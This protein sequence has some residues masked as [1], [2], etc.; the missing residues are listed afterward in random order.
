ME[1]HNL[2]CKL[3]NTDDMRE[4]R[5]GVIGNFQEFTTPWGL[6][7]AVYADYTASGRLMNQVE[8]FMLKE[9]FP[10]YS[11]THTRSNHF[12][13]KTTTMMNMARSNILTNVH[14]D[15]EKDA[16]I[17][18]GAGATG[19]INKFVSL[20]QIS[21]LAKASMKMKYKPVVF[22][23]SLEHHSTI[24]PWRESG[25]LVITIPEDRVIGCGPDLEILEIYLKKYKRCSSL[26][27]GSFSAASNVTGCMADTDKISS[28]LHK[29]NALACFDYACAGPYCDIR[30]NPI[31]DEH[32]AK[33]KYPSSYKDAV[34]ISTHK[35][36]GGP[37]GSG[38]LVCKKKIIKKSKPT[39]GSIGGGTV[40]WVSENK[41]AYLKDLIAREE[42]GT[43]DILGSIRASLAFQ[44][45][46]EIGVQRIH[47]QEQENLKRLKEG[48]ASN[49]NLVLLGPEF[50]LTKNNRLPIVSF[51]IKH[52]STGLYLHHAF[53]AT[54]LNDLY[55]IQVRS[56]CMC[57]GPY[58][59]KL[60]GLGTKS[61]KVSK[62][63]K[64]HAYI[65][66]GF[67]R[68]YL[69]FF[70]SREE[71]DYIIEAINDVATFGHKL[72]PYYQFDF[73]TS[74]WAIND[75]A[76]RTTT[77]EKWKELNNQQMRT[78][79]RTTTNEKWI[80]LNNQQMRTSTIVDSKEDIFKLNCRNQ[81]N[82]VK[83][84]MS[85]VS[86]ENVA[87]DVS[88]IQKHQID[89]K[90]C[91]FMWFALPADSFSNRISSN[92]LLNPENY[93]HTMKSS[94]GKKRSISNIGI[95]IY[96]DTKPMDTSYPF[97]TKEQTLQPL[98]RFSITEPL[99][100]SLKK[101]QSD[102]SYNGEERKRDGARRFFKK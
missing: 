55:G 17:F 19:A 36:V 92:K 28:L 54:L 38:V 33:E 70:A 85:S 1:S 26:M 37:G 23:S 20:L 77:N 86:F 67:T 51:L 57:A 89:S 64:D 102:F 79:F 3:I 47:L 41:H 62:V 8:N 96:H 42:G 39:E 80:E 44:I 14:G 63:L 25:A 49:D 71:V 6:K 88:T 52:S 43:P 15:E 12:G 61:E 22:I 98:H 29:H 24:L 93:D 101:V 90:I 46:Q 100:V 83:E 84:I 53:I 40:A 32:E 30:M 78:T 45:K 10:F 65:K 48:L 4:I 69:S 82:L 56:G 91:D 66:P 60:L 21:K 35:F 59:I 99:S 76:F 50:E 5:D 72:L 9:V 16:I 74:E 31:I 27:V 11:N 94:M 18:A 2:G 87:I 68:F 75:A 7:Q 81:L 73:E 34:F 13:S 97:D 58:A 95:N